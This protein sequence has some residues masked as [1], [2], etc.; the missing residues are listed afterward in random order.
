MPKGK[1]SLNM[2]VPADL[3][4]MLKNLSLETGLSATSIVIQYLEF[5]QAQHPSKRKVLSEKSTTT[6]KLDTT[7]PK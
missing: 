5:L 4:E 7:K 6:F 2:Y 1:M 3:H